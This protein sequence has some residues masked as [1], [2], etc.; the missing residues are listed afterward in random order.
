MSRS[1]RT[2]Q[3]GVAAGDESLVYKKKQGFFDN[4]VIIDNTFPQKMTV[5][6]VVGMQERGPPCH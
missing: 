4:F 6:P 3:V 2:T 5:L 1:V